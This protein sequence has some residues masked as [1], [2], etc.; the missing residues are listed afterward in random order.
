MKKLLCLVFVSFNAFSFADSVSGSGTY[1]NLNTGW[2]TMQGLPT[3]AWTGNFNAG[4]NFNRGF[5]LEGGYNL[6]SSSQYGS[7]TTGT[8]IFDVAAKGTIPLGDIFSLYGR[9]GIGLGYDSWSGSADYPCGICSASNNSY[10]LGLVGVGASFALGDHFDLRVENT[11][12]IPFTSG[13]F[14]GSYMNAVTGGVQFNF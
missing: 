14:N 7:A 1:L 11:A 2:A 6:L 9:L 8:N 4:Y 5:A 3:G 13:S 12:Y 10:A